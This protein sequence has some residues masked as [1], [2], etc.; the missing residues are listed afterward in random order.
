MVTKR[1]SAAASF[2][3][4]QK[5]FSMIEGLIAILILSIGVLGL[6]GLQVRTFQDSR[7][8]GDQSK[9]L[10]FAKEFAEIMR[11]NPA[12]ASLT[13]GNSYLFDTNTAG[14]L[15]ASTTNCQT[16]VCT[17]SQMA[18]WQANNW[19]SHVRATDA[20]P[21]GLNSPRVVVCYDNDPYDS[22]GLPVWDCDSGGRSLYIK[23]GWVVRT[24]QT[25][26]GQNVVNT[27]NAIKPTIILPV[28]LPVS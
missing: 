10:A 26:G 11:S 24:I 23:I 3:L 8:A 17:P 6:A 27:D 14:S 2:Q 18:L 5:G 13:T 4:R 1:L 19:L 21:S 7:D 22:D 15:A 25:S 9:A 20:D 28:S 12:H 16:S